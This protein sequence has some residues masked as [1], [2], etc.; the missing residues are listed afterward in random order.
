MS[1]SVEDNSRAEQQADLGQLAAEG[2]G[3]VLRVEGAAVQHE[4]VQVCGEADW[5]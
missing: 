1:A 2:L 5:F 3:V 4:E